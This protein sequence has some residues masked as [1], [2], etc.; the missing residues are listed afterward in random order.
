[1]ATPPASPPQ[2]PPAPQQPPTVLAWLQHTPW[3]PP[4]LWLAGGGTIGA[5]GL[6]MEHQRPAEVDDC[7]GTSRS[8]WTP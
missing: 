7:A 8:S 2:Q 1:M 4:V 5:G 6:G 3:L